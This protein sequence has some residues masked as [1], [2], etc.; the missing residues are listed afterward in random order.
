[1]IHNQSSG[2]TYTNE[3]DRQIT[4][5]VKQADKM[6]DTALVYYPIITPENYYY[7]CGDGALYRLYYF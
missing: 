4:A 2:R 3:A 1:M 5:K 6:L 7:F